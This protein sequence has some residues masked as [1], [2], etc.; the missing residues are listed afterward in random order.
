[1]PILEIISLTIGLAGLIFGIYQYLKRKLEKEKWEYHKEKEKLSF[2]ERRKKTDAEIYCDH[3]EQKFKYLDFTGLN[4]ILQKPLPLEKIYIKLRM[5]P[6]RSPINYPPITG[7]S[8]VENRQSDNDRFV[9]GAEDNFVTVF[10][11]LHHQ[12]TN[13]LAPLKMVILGHAGSGKTSLMKWIALQCAHAWKIEASQKK[14][15]DDNIFAHYIPVFIPLKDLGRDPGNTFREKNIKELTLDQMKKENISTSFFDEQFEA[16]RVIFLL[17]GLDEVADEGTRRDVIQW[18][19]NQK[20]KRN[21]LVVMSRFSGWRPEKGLKFHDAVPVYEISDFN[22]TDIKR[23]LENWYHNIETSVMDDVGQAE[24]KTAVKTGE[25]QYEDLMQI[26]KNNSYKN[27]RRLAV[28]PL[29]LTII[30]IVHRTRAVLPKDRHKLYEE[31]LKVMIELWNVANRRID[32]TFSVDNSLAYLSKL[33]FLLMKENQ[34]EID[35]FEIRE[36]L[37]AT[38]EGHPLDF[39]LYEIVLK[40]GLLYESYG[41]YGFV[42]RAFLEYLVALYF[43]R[44]NNPLDILAY[45]DR[46]YWHESFKLFVNIGNARL[47]FDEIIEY[48]FDSNYDYWQYMPLWIACLDDLVVEETRCVIEKKLFHRIVDFFELE[49]ETKDIKKI[50]SVL[51]GYA[52]E[53]AR[54]LE[55]MLY[56]NNPRY[57]AKQLKEGNYNVLDGQ[58]IN[59]EMFQKVGKYLKFDTRTIEKLLDFPLNLNDRQA[60]RLPLNAFFLLKRFDFPKLRES[61]V[62]IIS[63]HES[64]KIRIN[65]LYIFKRIN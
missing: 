10:S 15:E 13:K 12:A 62:S 7:Q 56:E 44:E 6:S 8:L 39:F 17:D 46:D 23:F 18:I 36:H 64:N 1:M 58:S 16:N 27:L 53:D 3:I 33:A 26:L 48:L 47:F 63:D 5:K 19:E 24:M 38:I 29:L 37:P 22:M 57:I 43:T 51:H 11:R 45:R 59:D 55:A 41:K 65:A 50:R 4:A 2:G 21:G 61:L 20:I 31:C 32:V 14:Q 49:L 30:A 40:A 34:R 35:I 42:N 9:D 54:K 60:N 52:Q 25:K 28:N